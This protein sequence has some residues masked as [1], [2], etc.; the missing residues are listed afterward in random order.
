MFRLPL[1]VFVCILQVALVQGQT[2]PAPDDLRLLIHNARIF[3]GEN[4]ID[5]NSILIVDGSITLI[6]SNLNHALADEWLDAQGAFL[7]PGLID[8]HVHT[9]APSMLEQSLI[10]GVT[11]N[12]DMFMPVSMKAQWRAQAASARDIADIFS[13]G[14]LITAAG[15]H[16]TQFGLPISTI[17]SPEN[18]Q[19]FIDDR[20]AEGSDYIK[21]VY[22]NGRSLGMDR[23]TLSRETLKAV[24]E[25]A[26]ARGK[27]AVV[28]IHDQQ[29]AIEAIQAG[30]DGLVHMFFDGLATEEFI[31]LAKERGVFIA[32]T[33]TVI[34]SVT[35]TAGGASLVTDEQLSPFLTP[36][37]RSNLAMS[38]QGLP[39]ELAQRFE[40][41]KQS[42]A[43][44]DEA[45][46]PIL[47]G[48][49]APNPGTVHGA[50]MHRELELLVE[51]GLEP[52]EALRAATSGPSDAFG[53]N[54]R[55]RIAKGL[56]ADLVLVTGDPTRTITD[57]RNVTRVWMGGKLADRDAY[58]A[59]IASL[60]AAAM[61]PANNLPADGLVSDFES[62]EPSTTFGTGWEVSTDSMMGGASTAETSII[63]GGANSSAHALE[64][65][66]ELKPGFQF[67]WAGALFN[68]GAQPFAPVNLSSRAGIS[69][70][71]R[72]DQGTCRIM[73][74]DQALGRI[75]ATV[76]V[77]ITGEWATHSIP[78]T[79]FNGIEG[80]GI[81]GI[82]FSAG[83][84][85]AFSFQIDD[86]RLQ[87][88]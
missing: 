22:D 54:D 40:E 9:F 2:D 36:E 31:K 70:T 67:P 1:V 79:D 51:S 59:N 21:I 49:D 41:L 5:A 88:K 69:F 15:G 20:I 13:A 50:A 52:I 24:I 62:D 53:L 12:L 48:T 8:C 11:T 32:P 65:K 23:P 10:F 17:D 61:H 80:T 71:I 44:L 75:P 14:T 45:G 81:M 68:P 37:D 72:G 78:F 33:L 74:F 64:V 42:I 19:K 83:A 63:D 46:V 76:D 29:A 39:P 25:A 56:R 30:A 55:G 82:L 18:A 26:H 60:A 16:G 66:G 73:V 3:D 77:P 43:M 38:F 34:Q 87:E 27:L 35:G 4:V 58:R 57:T 7:M 6:G 85:G 47:A 28:H 84:E 86:V